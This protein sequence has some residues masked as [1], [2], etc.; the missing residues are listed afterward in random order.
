MVRHGLTA[1]GRSHRVR[2]QSVASRLTTV[3][4]DEPRNARMAGRF[5]MIS[6]DGWF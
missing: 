4:V 3:C 5:A 1:P 2:R 6:G